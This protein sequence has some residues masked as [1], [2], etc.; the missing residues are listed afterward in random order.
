MDKLQLSELRPR[1]V[2]A[3]ACYN[4]RCLHGGPLPCDA[5]K[6]LDILPHVCGRVKVCPAHEFDPLA[7]REDVDR[8]RGLLDTGSAASIALSV[9]VDAFCNDDLQASRLF[10]R[11][12]V[13]LAALA[14]TR[15]PL[16]SSFSRTSNSKQA[17]LVRRCIDEAENSEKGLC[18]ALDARIPCHCL[19]SPMKVKL[20]GESPGPTWLLEKGIA[21][22]YFKRGD[23][24]QAGYRY[25]RAADLLEQSVVHET[26]QG[27]DRIFYGRLV[28]PTLLE[29]RTLDEEM[30]RIQSNISF[31]LMKNGN[32]TLALEAA[33]MA[34]KVGPD[35]AKAYACKGAALLAL[36][37]YNEANESLAMA[38][39]RAECMS[40]AAAEY[41]RLVESASDE[42]GRP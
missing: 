25:A 38:R 3:M 32:V 2:S 9:A 18:E 29:K 37:R 22:A 7:L 11:V 26:D 27:I 21:A 13:G 31:C 20:V 35:V 12:S 24:A 4:P 41:A 15:R 14:K 1:F 28:G 5:K 40:P 10:F 17:A 33:E 39:E 42:H 34:V 6:I 23:F 19:G 16:W 8:H 36:G 30:C